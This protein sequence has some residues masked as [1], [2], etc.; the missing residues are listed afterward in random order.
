MRGKT[1]S[2]NLG[3]GS[4]AIFAS[5]PLSLIVSRSNY[6][7]LRRGLSRDDELQFEL[8]PAPVNGAV[9]LNRD[10]EK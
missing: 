6:W 1:V 5:L 8:P 3:R 7:H 10:Y 4:L 2:Y 9:K